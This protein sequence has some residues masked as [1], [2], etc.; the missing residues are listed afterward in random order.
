MQCAVANIAVMQFVRLA[1]AWPY[2]YG[3]TRK[4]QLALTFTG[5]TLLHEC[6]W[7]QSAHD[8]S[9]S[10]VAM[11]TTLPYGSEFLGLTR[12]VHLCPLMDKYHVALL[13]TLARG[14]FLN[15]AVW[16]MGSHVDNRRRSGRNS[17]C[18]CLCRA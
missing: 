18:E 10:L 6:R 9:V 14:T 5:L 1:L 8:K 7:Y 13:R 4:L 3:C 12:Q 11:E 2:F 17:D 15:C 16:M